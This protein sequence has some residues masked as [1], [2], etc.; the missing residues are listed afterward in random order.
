MTKEEEFVVIPLDQWFQKQKAAWRVHKPKHGTSETGWD[1]EVNRKNQDLLIEA[2][3]IDKQPF[4]SAFAGLVMAPL[5]K[6]PQKHTM[7][8]KDRSWCHYICWAIGIAPDDNRD[9]YQMLFDYFDRNLVFWKHYCK[10]LRLKYIFFVKDRKV[11][12]VPFAALI[13]IASHYGTKAAGA[14]LKER[15]SLAA[16]LMSKYE[17]S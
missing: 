2:K 15:R 16:E 8:T 6:R 13:D 9:I 17:Y 14:K 4:T 10:D 1:L 3:F 12:K 5:T 11:S 7:K